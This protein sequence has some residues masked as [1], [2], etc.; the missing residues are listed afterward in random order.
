MIYLILQVIPISISIAIVVEIF[1]QYDFVLCAVDFFFDGIK[2]RK[3]F[4]D[5]VV[6]RV[7]LKFVEAFCILYYIWRVK[8]DKI[9][10]G[11][12]VSDRK[13]YPVTDV[14]VLDLG[15]RPSKI[16]LMGQ[17]L[18]RVRPGEDDVVFSNEKASSSMIEDLK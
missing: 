9:N 1:N 12:G 8:K 17:D 14:D 6:I 18:R 16:S 4:K 3:L 5:L 13:T 11:F 10:R 2:V 7:S 15:I